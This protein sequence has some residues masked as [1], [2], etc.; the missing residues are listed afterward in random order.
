[1][2]V[3]MCV[4]FGIFPG[5]HGP[6]FVVLRYRPRFPAVET[7][8]R[9]HALGFRR[10]RD[11]CS[12]H[13]VGL[14]SPARRGNRRW[15]DGGQCS[16]AGGRIGRNGL[17]HR[18]VVR[19]GRPFEA[20]TRHFLEPGRPALSRLTEVLAGPKSGVY[21][22]DL[23]HKAAFLG[24]SV[25]PTSGYRVGL[26]CGLRCAGPFMALGVVVLLGAIGVRDHRKQITH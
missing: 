21:R 10:G 15:G 1:M 25:G 23:I 20:A 11:L 4:E 16:P 26:R 22:E 2:T 9:L 19:Q 13:L 6:G 7:G 12:R 5:G 8:V 18:A 17:V 24:K 14:A 3:T